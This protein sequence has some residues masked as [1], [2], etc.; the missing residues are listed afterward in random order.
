MVI[1]NNPIIQVMNRYVP[2]VPGEADLILSYFTEKKYKRNDILLHSGQLAQ[3]VFFVETG[4]L[5]QFYT[6]D[7][8]IDRTCNFIFEG[9]FIT[10]LESFSKK[11]SAT[12]FIQALEPATCRVIKCA[13]LME[14]MDASPATREFFRIIVEQVASESIRRTRSLQSSSPEKAF[15]ELLAQRPDIFQRVPQRL[16]AQYLGIAPESLSRIKKRMMV[17]AKS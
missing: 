12:C 16:V 6:D 2:L 11:Q 13:E 1:D 9:E 3:D 5:H 14:L 10:D 7:K 17:H 8:G 4:A 15:M